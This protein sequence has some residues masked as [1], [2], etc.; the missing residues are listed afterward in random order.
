MSWNDV[1][2]DPRRPN[3]T[4]MLLAAEKLLKE[5][6]EANRA[7]EVHEITVLADRLGTLCNSIRARSIYLHF[8]KPMQTL[9]AELEEEVE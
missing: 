7:G 9:P 2:D 6:S 5:I 3:I 8:L 1:S 4:Q